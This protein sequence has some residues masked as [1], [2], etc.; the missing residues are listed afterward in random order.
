MI[1]KQ[2]R[3]VYVTTDGKEHDSFL[4]AS[5]HLAFTEM[6]AN[7][8]ALGSKNFLATIVDNPELFISI[9]SRI[10]DKPGPTT[11]FLATE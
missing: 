1:R 5:R 11:N 8:A 3:D 9:L 6:Q 4:A 2:T 10:A 7:L